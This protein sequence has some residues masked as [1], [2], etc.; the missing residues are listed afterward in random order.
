MSD[1]AYIYFFFLFASPDNALNDLG[2]E[3]GREIEEVE[4]EGCFCIANRGTYG[5]LMS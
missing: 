2:R 1:V 5:G 4:S 3:E